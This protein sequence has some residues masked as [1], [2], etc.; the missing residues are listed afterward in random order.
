MSRI[1]VGM[2][3]VAM[4]VGMSCAVAQEGLDQQPWY[5]STSISGY[6]HARY[7]AWENDQDGFDFRRM[8]VTV[9][10]AVNDQTTGIITL[11]RVGGKGANI[12]LYNAFVDYKIN[13]QYSMQVGQ[14]P[15]WFGLEGWEGS[16]SRL[17]L[18]R[19]RILEGTPA[20]GAEG[21]WVLGAPDR[22]VWLRRNPANAS[23]PLVVVG[24]SNGQFREGEQNTAKNV[25]VDVKF[26]R[27]WGMFGASW[28]DGTLTPMAPLTA[29]PEADRSAVAAYVRIFPAPFGFQAEWADGEMMGRDRD[30][31]YVQGMYDTGPGTAFARWEEYTADPAGVG[32]SQIGAGATNYDA[33]HV[34][35]AW[36]LDNAN[37]ITVEYVDAEQTA[38]AV[39]ARTT[40]DD[41]YGG[42]QWQFAFK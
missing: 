7:I 11:S 35:Y 34:G 41:S 1:I 9:R 6:F 3:L 18:R 26:K 42:I 16:M 31:Y 24:V 13:D 17:P 4:L 39:G 27:D 20:P 25:S 14:T 2:V 36:K 40:M 37:Q 23:E 21:F 10:S 29:G 28:F 12:D 5:K 32:T 8:Y 38:G 30:G 15:T 19:A 22:G 33:L